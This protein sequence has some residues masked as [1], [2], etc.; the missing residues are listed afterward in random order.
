MW[1]RCTRCLEVNIL[2]SGSCICCQIRWV[3]SCESWWRSDL[4]SNPDYI[5]AGSQQ[6][7]I[8]AL[9]PK[10]NPPVRQREWVWRTCQHV[11]KWRGR[12]QR[13]RAL[14]LV[15]Q[16][17]QWGDAED[18]E[19]FVSGV[20]LKYDEHNV[21]V[22]LQSFSYFSMCLCFCFFCKAGMWV[23]GWLWQFGLGGDRGDAASLGGLSRLHSASWP[24]PPTR[25]GR[26]W[27]PDLFQWDLWA[28]VLRNGPGP[29]YVVL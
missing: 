15:S 24:H 19:P 20:T 1:S 8:V 28:L 29:K 21:S 26:L 10:T 18:A 9:P 6:P 17:D 12:G 14:W 27:S 4:L 2:N 11:W 25:R 5:P 7:T 22:F 13:R 23:W 3:T 16:S